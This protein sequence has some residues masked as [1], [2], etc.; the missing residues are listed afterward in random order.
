VAREE[1]GV[2]GFVDL[3]IL[4]DMLHEASLGYVATLVVE[5]G[6]WGEGIGSALLER[7]L[8]EA[9][10]KGLAELHVATEKDNARA[11]RLYSRLGF[12]GE[13]LLL[14]WERGKEEGA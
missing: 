9:R 11:R 13:S 1:G 3:W 10:E 12:S 6:R 7:V 2:V 4:P 5:T 14:E 8:D